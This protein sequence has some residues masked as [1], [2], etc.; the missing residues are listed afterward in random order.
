MAIW[1]LLLGVATAVLVPLMADDPVVPRPPST[2]QV[3]SGH[4]FRFEVVES[5]DARYAGD[6]PG[7]IG[8]GGGI[9]GHPHVALGDEVYRVGPG[10][11]RAI[12]VVTGVKWDRLKESLTVEFHPRGDDRI[13]VGDEVWLDVSP[14]R[15]PMASRP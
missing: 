5:F 6:T 13:A 2:A 7:H 9:S 11:D 1:A 14:D 12:G 3:T 4:Q 8:R 10:S 15:P